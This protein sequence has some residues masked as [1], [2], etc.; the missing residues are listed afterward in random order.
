MKKKLFRIVAIFGIA[1]INIVGVKAATGSLSVSSASSAVVGNNVTVT[2]KASSSNIFYWQFFVTYDSSRLKLIS[3]STTIQGEAGGEGS[4]E[5]VNNVTRTFKFQAISAGTAFVTVTSGSGGMNINTNGES[6]SYSTATK[7]IKISLPTPKSTN[8]SLSALLID[9][10]TITPEFNKNTLE[11]S[12]TLEPNTITVNIKTA[13]EDSKATVTGAG[14]VPLIEGLNTISLVVTA[15]NGSTKTYTLLLTVK[16]LDP[17]NIKV[18]GKEYK[19]IRKADQ[20]D[21]FSTFVPKVITYEGNDIPALYN[22]IVKYTIVGAKDEAGNKYYFRYDAKAKTFIKY[23]ELNMD[24]IIFYPLTTN[25][26]PDNKMYKPVT[27]IINNIKINGYKMAKNSEFALVY[28]INV[29]NNQEGFYLYDTI[30]KTM[31]RYNGEEYS[32]LH[33]DIKYYMIITIAFGIGMLLCF[34]IIFSTLYTKAKHKKNKELK[35]EAEAVINEPEVVSKEPNEKKKK[36]K[37]K[38]KTKEPTILD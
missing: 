33:N 31:Q 23:Q 16:E 15:E 17:I 19:L 13:L 37:G 20:L 34:A 4:I 36:D 8:N 38:D 6:I 25:K 12:A 3:G 26:K 35:K 9:G 18:D 28:G 27:V 5:V 29:E 1:F 21:T 30:A 32:L 10:V 22:A 2:V 7:N 11:Y 14:D 24:G